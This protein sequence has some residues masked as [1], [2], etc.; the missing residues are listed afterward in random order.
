VIPFALQRSR[1]SPKSR[2]LGASPEF[3][4]AL[5]TPRDTSSWDAGEVRKWTGTYFTMLAHA[6]VRGGGGR[7]RGT[8]TGRDGRG[9]GRGEGLPV[10]AELNGWTV[11]LTAGTHQHIAPPVVVRSS[12]TPAL[13][14]A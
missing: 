8:G 4:P 3:S 13:T 2:L 9:E 1:E 10:T 11:L 7:G 14:V 5:E 12:V 6:L